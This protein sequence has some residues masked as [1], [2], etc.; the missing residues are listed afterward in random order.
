MQLYVLVKILSAKAIISDSDSLDSKE[1]NYRFLTMALLETI[2]L[3][4]AG[5]SMLDARSIK[6]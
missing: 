3:S 1:D 2:D 6:R 4:S 5:R